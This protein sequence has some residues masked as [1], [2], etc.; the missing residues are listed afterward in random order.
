MLYKTLTRNTESTRT[1]SAGLRE[2]TFMTC[3]L[4][5]REAV[6]ESPLHTEATGADSMLFMPYQSWRAEESANSIVE[7][8]KQKQ[9]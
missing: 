3:E 8:T 9:S 5:P 2:V 6:V 4:H 1:H 7:Y